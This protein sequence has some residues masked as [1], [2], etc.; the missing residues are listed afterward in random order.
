MPNINELN[1]VSSP[2]VQS[3]NTKANKST[4]KDFAKETQK[5]MNKFI[6]MIAKQLQYQTPDNPMDPKDLM[7]VSSNMFFV[8]LGIGIN[9]TLTSLVEGIDELKEVLLQQKGRDFLDFPKN[10]QTGNINSNII[11]DSPSLVN[12]SDDGSFTLANDQKRLILPF[13]IDAEEDTGNVNA[14]ISILDSNGKS[15]FQQ[16]LDNVKPGSNKLEWLATDSTGNKLPEGNYKINVAIKDKED[17]SLVD[18]IINPIVA[19][20]KSVFD[21]GAKLAKDFEKTLDIKS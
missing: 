21:K 19:K 12:I 14:L 1:S 4:D 13:R 3:Q 5:E 17:D 6:G 20:A 9:K 18:G 8:N 16:L 10:S 7:Q 2:A 11:S 15:V